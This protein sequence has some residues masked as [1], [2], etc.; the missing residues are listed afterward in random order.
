MM[1]VTYE[2]ILVWSGLKS[3]GCDPTEGFA[4]EAV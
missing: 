2:T 3:G 4:V 1:F